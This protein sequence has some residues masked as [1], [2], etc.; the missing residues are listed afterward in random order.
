MALTPKE[1][2]FASTVEECAAPPAL[3]RRVLPVCKDDAREARATRGH[4]RCARR[5]RRDSLTIV[6]ADKTSGA[7]ERAHTSDRL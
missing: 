3:S 7:R 6:F 4:R 2:A 5:V 1:F